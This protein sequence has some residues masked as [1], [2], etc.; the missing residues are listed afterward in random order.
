[1]RETWAIKR[2]R[3]VL[4]GLD[5]SEGSDSLLTVLVSAAILS[6]GPEPAML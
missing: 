3:N 6:E 2:A 5:S 4:S 1:M